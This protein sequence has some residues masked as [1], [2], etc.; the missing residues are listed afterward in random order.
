MH[1]TEDRLQLTNR[2][3]LL[4]GP[5]T[6]ANSLFFSQKAIKAAL[7]LSHS[8]DRD[9]HVLEATSM[10]TLTSIVAP[11][12]GAKKLE[13]RLTFPRHF[14]CSDKLEVAAQELFLSPDVL[15][16]AIS[17][18]Q[19]NTLAANAVLL[20]ASLVSK[21]RAVFETLATN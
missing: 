10:K 7:F 6:A 11:Y 15:C 2:F 13:N 5:Q 14:F 8:K 17:T 1:L 12:G 4:I 18:S 21:K 19:E 3:S 16:S 20:D 9:A